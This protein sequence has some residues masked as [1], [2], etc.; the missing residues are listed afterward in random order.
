MIAPGEYSESDMDVLRKNANSEIQKAIKDA[1]EAASN[2][3]IA[4]IAWMASGEAKRG[5]WDH[6]ELHTGALRTL[7]ERKG[8][9]VYGLLGLVESVR[10]SRN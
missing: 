3:I 6:F 9:L 1:G 4:A 2:N 7:A 10:A 8:A 5:E